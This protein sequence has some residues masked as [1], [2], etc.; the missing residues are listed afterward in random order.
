MNQQFIPL[1]A[2]HHQGVLRWRNKIVE[3]PADANK[4]RWVLGD[5]GDMGNCPIC[6][7]NE[8]LG[9]IDID[10]DG[11]W[12]WEPDYMNAHPNCTCDFQYGDDRGDR[13]LLDPIRKEQPEESKY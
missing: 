1:V 4:K 10:D 9:W 5:G 2:R 3:D 8:G 11:S 13:E 12:D 7:G 6:I